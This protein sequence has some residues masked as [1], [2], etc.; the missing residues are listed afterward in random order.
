MVPAARAC[1]ERDDGEAGWPAV[2]GGVGAQEV[3]P[4][5]AWGPQSGNGP[6]GSATILDEP[7]AECAE[8]LRRRAATITWAQPGVVTVAAAALRTRTPE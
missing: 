1:V 8:P 6:T 5:R 2:V 4:G 7:F 3:Y